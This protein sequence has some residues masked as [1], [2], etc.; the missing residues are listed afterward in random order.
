MRGRIITQRHLSP[1]SSLQRRAPFN[2]VQFQAKDRLEEE[3]ELYEFG[4]YRGNI[5][6]P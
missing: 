6:T 4:W 1:R 2:N 5:E 3:L